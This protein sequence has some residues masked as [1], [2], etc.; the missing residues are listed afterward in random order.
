MDSVR[1]R[2]AAV[3]IRDDRVL[4]VRERGPDNEG[5]HLGHEYW[6]LPGGGIEPNHV[7]CSPRSVVFMVV[8]VV[9]GASIYGQDGT[10]Q[11]YPCFRSVR[12]LTFFAM[13]TFRQGGPGSGC[14]GETTCSSSEG[15]KEAGASAQGSEEA[16][17]N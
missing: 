1:L 12:P 14:C 17:S 7:E 6:T 16:R 5:R 9:V 8:R 2:V 10:W 15:D 13:N 11:V 4:M 3:I